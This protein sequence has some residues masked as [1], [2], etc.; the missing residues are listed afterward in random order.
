MRMYTRLRAREELE[1]TETQEISPVSGSTWWVPQR[2]KSVA[3]R[4][5]DKGAY[6]QV[7]AELPALKRPLK[8]PPAR[9]PR[10]PRAKSRP[11][12]MRLI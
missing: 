12:G 10:H 7:S 8:D 11:A 4:K 5:K 9:R 6:A 3:L 1:H 2:Q